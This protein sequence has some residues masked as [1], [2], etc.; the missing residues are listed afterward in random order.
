MKVQ[1]LIA[2]FLI[3]GLVVAQD[4][5][6]DADAFFSKYVK[7]GDVEYSLIK[8]NPNQLSQLVEQVE[9]FS[10]GRQ[11]QD[12]QMAFYCNAYNIMVIKGIVDAYPVKSPMDVQGFFD[13]KN[14]TV[15]GEKMSLNDL[16]NNKVRPMGDAR[17]HF[18]LVCAAKGCPKI[19]GEA[20]F[21]DRVQDQLQQRA[22][23]AMN[24]PYFI[25]YPT[26]NK[27]VEVSQI[28]DWYS[29]DFGGGGKILEY[30]NGFRKNKIP[31]TTKVGYYNYDW[32]LNEKK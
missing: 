20:I 10:I 5:F 16:E 26:S 15:A 21:P 27:K 13:R 23:T 1:I 8:S 31:D 29:A 2:F 32:T 28:F 19:Q 22:E 17:I 25:R 14:I 30:V 11:N 7:D 24:D 4:F 18:A 3:P 12:Y 6:Q 9:S